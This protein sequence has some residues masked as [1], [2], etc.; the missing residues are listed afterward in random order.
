[1]G[2]LDP[3]VYVLDSDKYTYTDSSDI[4]LLFHTLGNELMRYI[5]F[6]VQ[7]NLS[8]PLKLISIIFLM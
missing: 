2:Y 6:C 4:F 1:M 7:Q 8:V 5:I 3:V